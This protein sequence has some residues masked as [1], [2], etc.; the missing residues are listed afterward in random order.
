[1]DKGSPPKQNKLWLHSDDLD[2]FCEL[3]IPLGRLCVSY[4]LMVMII[5]VVA[6]RS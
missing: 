4:K 5:Q 2:D 6:G 1:M 3:V